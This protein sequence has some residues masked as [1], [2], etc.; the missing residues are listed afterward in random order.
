M[1]HLFLTLSVIL[2]ISFAGCGGSSEANEAKTGEAQTATETNAGAKTLNVDATTSKVNWTGFGVGHNHTGNLALKEGSVNVEN[3]NIVSGK[4]T[5]D[6][7]QINV[8]DGTSGDDLKKLMG[9]LSSG[10]FKTDSFPTSSFEITKV[11]ALSGDPKATHTITG[12]L[13]LNGITKSLSFPAKVEMNGDNLSTA[14]T[15]KFNRTLWN[16]VENSKTNKL[17][18]LKKFANAAVEDDIEMTLDIK[19]AATATAAK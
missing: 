6:M 11:E 3:G 1:K 7:K 5:F 8:T 17:F 19:A 10:F 13:N 4:F 18:D 9:H 15:F 12:N 2:M 16:I 14:A